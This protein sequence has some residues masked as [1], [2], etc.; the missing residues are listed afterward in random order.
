MANRVVDILET[1]TTI[2]MFAVGLAQWIQGGDNSMEALLNQQGYSLKRVVGQ[3]D[4][5]LLPDWT[6][7]QCDETHTVAGAE[8]TSNT[9]SSAS[10]FGLHTRLLM[11]LLATVATGL[12][13]ALLW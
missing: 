2:P 11:T 12:V 3:Y 1:T 6:D 8:P 5:T 7:A 9:A 10:T 13:G 4:S